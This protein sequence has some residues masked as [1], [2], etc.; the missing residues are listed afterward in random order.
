MN[1]QK[2]TANFNWIPDLEVY[3]SQFSK[4]KTSVSNGDIKASMNSSSS[5][6]VN[7]NTNG[8]SAD[9]NMF[10]LNGRDF[11]SDP[12]SMLNTDMKQLFLSRV[13]KVSTLCQL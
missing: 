4:H 12:L 11:A 3:M 9:T 10:S 1:N 2:L 6:S 7:V 8:K 5:G 13:K